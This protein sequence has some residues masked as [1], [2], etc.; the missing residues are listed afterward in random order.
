MNHNLPAKDVLQPGTIPRR[1]RILCLTADKEE[2][3]TMRNIVISDIHG[4]DW[5]LQDLLVMVRA[6]PET[7]R[8]ILL[9]DLF[10]RG[11]D[12]W[13][14]FQT[15]QGLADSFGENFVLLRGNHEDYL[16]QPRL[17]LSEKMTWNRVG[18]KTT[19]KSF[20]E[21]GEKMEDTIP[22]LQEHC[23]MYYKGE[24]FQCAHAGVRKVPIEENDA[25]TLIHDHTIVFANKYDG[26]LT[27]TGH[28]ALSQ[29]VWFGGDGQTD[30]LQT[31]TPYPLP[32]TGVICIDTGCGKNGKLTAMV[33][34]DGK[35]TLYSVSEA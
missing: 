11:P 29:P 28:V 32:E 21:H 4:C 8:L 2:T 18:R 5:P 7:D 34:D 35:Y 31:N 25:Y 19:V 15:V 20:K 17:S 26:P 33:I 9:G 6:R 1:P 23:V 10:D 24:G 16:L 27:I 30:F 12:S 3:Q 13:Q 22:W 14:V